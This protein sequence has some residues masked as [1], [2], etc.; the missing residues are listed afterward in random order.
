[1]LFIL[2]YVTKYTILLDIIWNHKV[3]EKN[4]MK[5]EG[6]LLSY[7]YYYEFI[8]YMSMSIYSTK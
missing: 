6:Y 4:L 8:F 1:M 3:M 5:I 2:S 7:R